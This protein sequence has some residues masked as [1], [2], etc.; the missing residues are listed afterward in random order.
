MAK[1][2]HISRS[3]PVK[4]QITDQ[5]SFHRRKYKTLTR[6]SHRREFGPGFPI[7][8]KLHIL[9]S[10]DNQ[11]HKITYRFDFLAQKHEMCLQ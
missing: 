5:L 2:L 8:L 11:R 4:P 6:F 9:E 7:G 3:D 1:T 10:I